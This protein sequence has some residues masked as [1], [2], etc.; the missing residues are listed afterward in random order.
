MHFLLDNPLMMGFHACTPVNLLCICSRPVVGHC[1][2]AQLKSIETMV[3]FHIVYAY[4]I[5]MPFLPDKPFGFNESTMLEDAHFIRPENFV[6]VIDCS[7][8]YF[9]N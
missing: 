5:S 6:P 7:L 4:L 2:C 3:C 9:E 8:L 1:K